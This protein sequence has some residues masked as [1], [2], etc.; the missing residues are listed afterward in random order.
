MIK[1]LRIFFVYAINVIISHCTFIPLIYD[2][3]M[4]TVDS[5]KTIELFH[6]QWNEEF[7]TQKLVLFFEFNGYKFDFFWET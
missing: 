3:I 4:T 7:R 5:Y 6:F 2:S 1:T